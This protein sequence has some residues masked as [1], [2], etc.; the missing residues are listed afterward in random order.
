VALSDVGKAAAPSAGSSGA[1]ALPKV[2]CRLH[3]AWEEG[4]LH[5]AHNCSPHSSQSTNKHTAIA[6]LQ[7]QMH[8]CC[9]AGQGTV[10]CC[11]SC[12]LQSCCR[13]HPVDCPSRALPRCDLLLPLCWL[14][15]DPGRCWAAVPPQRLT[16]A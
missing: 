8:N 11:C 3:P 14:L 16:P 10:C 9:S 1:H 5:V 15:G 7:P 4:T 12:T 2:E 13:V 6:L